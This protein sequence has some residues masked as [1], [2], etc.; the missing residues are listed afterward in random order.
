MSI[1]SYSNVDISE[2]S[3]NSI[4]NNGKIHMI[5]NPPT[6]AYPKGIFKKIY[7]L[8][9]NTLRDEIV[10][11]EELSNKGYEPT[12]D[13]VMGEPQSFNVPVPEYIKNT[14]NEIMNQSED[15]KMKKIYQKK[16][17]KVVSTSKYL[18]KSDIDKVNWTES[19]DIKLKE[20]MALGP[21]N[22][23]TKVAKKF[24]GRTG[25]QCRERWYNH[26]RP[27]IKKTAWSEEED[28]ILI[29]AHKVLGTKW[30]EIAQQLPG[31]SDNNIKN[32]WNTT[33]RRVQN[34][35]GGT[36]NP[37]GNNILEN[38]IRCITINNEDF[39]KTDGSYGEP[40]NIESDDD[41]KDML[42]GEMNLSLETI[43]TQTTKPLTNA[44]TTSPYVQMPE[45]N[46]TMEDCESL[47]DILELLR[48]WE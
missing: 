11:N 45:D 22:K 48:W 43:T 39:L 18:K 23:W 17:I 6:F 19:E 36:V 25:K 2:Q 12:L 27:N 26:A 44:S 1:K 29:E 37:V 47:E 38:Y 16:N 4:A 21:K 33:K 3:M 40:T 24:E 41:S 35:R 20:I 10:Y 7:D 46:Y 5:D 30:V 13:Q 8:R 34:K 28:Q 9:G 31:R 32:P 42:Y 15:D 14:T